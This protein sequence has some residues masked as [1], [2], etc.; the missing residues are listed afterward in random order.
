M[1]DPSFFILLLMGIFFPKGESGGIENPRGL[2]LFKGSCVSFLGSFFGTFCCSSRLKVCKDGASEQQFSKG[3]FFPR[4]GVKEGEEW[5]HP[6]ISPAELN[7]FFLWA[8]N[9]QNWEKHKK[10]I[11]T[12]GCLYI[13]FFFSNERYLRKPLILGRVVKVI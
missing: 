12:S 10:K 2:F 1:D 7:S 8:G 3:N 9:L 6:R 13:Y 11:Q 4:M 5:M